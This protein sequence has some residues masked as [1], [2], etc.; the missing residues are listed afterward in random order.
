[1][2][3]IVKFNCLLLFCTDFTL[4][5]TSFQILMGELQTSITPDNT[6]MLQ[7]LPHI[8]ALLERA[9]SV[10]RAAKNPDNPIQVLVKKENIAPGENKELQ[11]RLKKTT[12]TPGRKKRGLVLRYTNKYHSLT[13]MHAIVIL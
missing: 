12:K 9:V 10:C 1:M 7:F 8:N 11:W 5:L 2:D 13:I 4:Q 3:H 6:Y